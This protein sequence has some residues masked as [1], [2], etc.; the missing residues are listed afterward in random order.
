MMLRRQCYRLR[1]GALLPRCARMETA[2]TTNP[3]RRPR[4]MSH[5]VATHRAHARDD[6]GALDSFAAPTGRA[7][8]DGT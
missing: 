4:A 8:N 1:L 7:P 2:S 6:G 3:P 5:R